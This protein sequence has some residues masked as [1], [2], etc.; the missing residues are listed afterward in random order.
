MPDGS[1]GL[2]FLPY[3][4]GERTPHWDPDARGVFFGIGIATA[5]ADFI[6]AIMEGVSFALRHN[7]ETVE[8]LGIAIDEI[9]FLGGGS[10]SPVWLHTLAKILNK[11]V[12]TLG[13]SDAGA[14]GAVMLCGHALGVYPSVEHAIEAMV[15]TSEE[16]HYPDMPA[17]YGK[18]YGLFLELYDNLRGSFAKAAR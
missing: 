12:K 2:I 14:L 11:P 15:A 4:N 17:V 18:Q 16:I 6:K 13:G 3:L 9:R 1:N 8:G 7:V 10:K 5:K